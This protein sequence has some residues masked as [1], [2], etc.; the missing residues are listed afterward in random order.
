MPTAHVSLQGARIRRRGNSLIV[1][2]S[3]LE[4]AEAIP[5]ARLDR[6]FLFGRVEIGAAALERLMR[7]EVPVCFLSRSGR[8]RGMAGKHMQHGAG[9]RM[10]QHMAVAD[11]CFCLSAA[12]RIVSQKLRAMSGVIGR[13]RSNHPSPELATAIDTFELS[14]RAVSAAGDQSTLRGIEG[15]ACR[16][17]FACLAR[18]DRTGLGFRGRTSRPALDPFNAL[19][20]FGYALVAAEIHG[21]TMAAGLDPACGFYHVPH[22][23]RPS[24]VLDVMEPWRHLIVDQLVLRLTNLRMLRQEHF[25][26]LSTGA[27]RL[28][29]D[30]LA[31]F[32]VEFESRMTSPI[33][34]ISAMCLQ[35]EGHAAA[36][37]SM[38]HCLYESVG[39]WAT[40]FSAIAR[41]RNQL[42]ALANEELEA[43]LQG[44]CHANAA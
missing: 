11:P 30:G 28:T 7:E 18:A 42:N 9:A 22:G 38:R 10:G 26:T 15:N 23:N 12:Q 27:V 16:E 44:D 24:F 8:W 21:A 17:Y 14:Q 19:L 20:N 3:S 43:A 5:I 36:E 1:E 39:G 25:H 37:R 2:H 29:E 40:D 4:R 32:V 34:S 35:I 13:I 6:L 33:D 41:Q 31:Q